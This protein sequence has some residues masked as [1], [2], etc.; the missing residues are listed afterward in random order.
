MI[1]N[2]TIKLTS[3]DIEANLPSAVKIQAILDAK[4]FIK[5]IKRLINCPY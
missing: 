1:E 2:E 3:K 4:V 5:N